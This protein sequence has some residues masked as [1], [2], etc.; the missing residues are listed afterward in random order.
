MP[1]PVGTHVTAKAANLSAEA[2]RAWVRRHPGEAPEGAVL[3]GVVTGH[4][5][6]WTQVSFAAAHPDRPMPISLKSATLTP[7]EPV[8]RPSRALAADSGV[9]AADDENLR[10]LD[11]H[12]EDGD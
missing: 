3:T 1:L 5:G 2:R 12:G 7:T 6:A 9:R 11:S 10:L 4:A 8:R